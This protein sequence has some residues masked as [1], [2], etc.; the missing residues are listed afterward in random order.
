V[1]QQYR[2]VIGTSVR[3]QQ[4]RRLTR[5]LRPLPS[6][7]ICSRE[8]RAPI[9]PGSVV[10]FRK[11]VRVGFRYLVCMIKTPAH[12]HTSKVLDFVDD[13]IFAETQNLFALAL[14]PHPDLYAAVLHCP[15]QRADAR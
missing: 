4:Q 14:T 1:E 11:N 15:G 12:C 6:H 3:G 10:K 13:L 8:Q 7:G 9:V 5:T 2:S